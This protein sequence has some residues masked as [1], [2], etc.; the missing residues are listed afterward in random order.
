MVRGHGLAQKGAPPFT[1]TFDYMYFGTRA[2][3]LS[4]LQ[5]PPEIEPMLGGAVCP[6]P[7]EEHPSDH[8]PIAA[9]F[10]FTQAMHES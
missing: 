9:A 4:A 1:A 6:L 7:N 10:E 8:L 3:R 2:L 5:P